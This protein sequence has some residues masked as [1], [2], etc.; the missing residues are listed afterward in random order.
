MIR[1][2][3]LRAGLAWLILI[4]IAWISA[5]QVDQGADFSGDGM[6]HMK[7]ARIEMPPQDGGF[8][9]GVPIEVLYSGHGFATIGNESHILRLKIESIMP[10]DPA[11]I[12][13]LLSSNRS[14]EEIRDEIRATET[15]TGEKALRGSM[16]LDRRIYPLVD[17]AI[18][19]EENNSTMIQAGLAMTGVSG[20]GANGTESDGMGELSVLI[21]RTDGGSIGN[22]ELL[23][24]SGERRGRYTILLDFDSGK[25][26]RMKMMRGG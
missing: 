8:P 12:R 26:E 6:E 3:I 14:L 15:E 18:S 7:D 25:P 2:G 13:D 21:S 10:I 17:I 9:M 23:I 4:C 19:P 16:L 20:S 11:Q 1:R 22:G 5:A 24:E